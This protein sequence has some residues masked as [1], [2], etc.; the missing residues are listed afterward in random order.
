MKTKGG[1]DF[2]TVADVA[3]ELGI[4]VSSVKRYI[5]NQTFPPPRREFFGKQSVAVF[6]ELEMRKLEK[7]LR[8]ARAEENKRDE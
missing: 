5:R 7:I 8:E 2:L 3:K 1:K 6:T 4:S